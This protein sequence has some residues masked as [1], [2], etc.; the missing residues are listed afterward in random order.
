MSCDGRFDIVDAMFIAQYDV[1]LRT[2]A[3]SC[4][5][6]NPST[7]LHAA[8]GDLNGDSV[9]N[10]VDALIIARCVVGMAGQHCP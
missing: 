7:Q 4:S 9:T 10:V 1:G 6:S 2:D 5:M 3:G 8:R